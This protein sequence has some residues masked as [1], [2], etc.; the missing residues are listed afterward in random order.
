MELVEG[1]DLACSLNRGQ[2]FEPGEVLDVA[3]GVARALRAAWSFKIVH[4]DIKPSNILRTPDGRVKVADFGLA[5]S[6]RMPRTDSQLIAGTAE[7]LSPEQAVGLKVDIRAD[8]YSL[9]V[10]LYELV[11]GRPPFRADRS[12]T[13]VIYQHV[14]HPPPPLDEAVPDVPEPLAA[15]IH[16]CLIKEAAG[17]FKDP[18]DFIEEIHRVRALFQA[19]PPTTTLRSLPRRLRRSLRRAWTHPRRLAAGR[20]ALTALLVALVALAFALPAVVQDNRRGWNISP[21]R[22]SF[23]LA[24]DLGDFASARA[25]AERDWGRESREYREVERQERL[26]L[27][28]DREQTARACVQREDWEGAA[29]AFLALQA[30]AAG[31]DRE[32]YAHA[33]EYLRTLARGREL[34]EQGA[35]EAALAVYRSL[36]SQGSLYERYLRERV[37]ALE[38]D[39]R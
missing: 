35:R 39:S 34:E 17:R 25:I 13:G 5:K 20:V 32:R 27:T 29:A 14:H 12:S 9:G 1:E 11:A 3:E 23:D 24:L 28:F 30:D 31:A 18:D 8:L 15:M 16:R 7:Y 10:V 36:L 38:Q 22:K 21:S 33:G 19:S 26:A 37:K 2:T 4:R 6:L